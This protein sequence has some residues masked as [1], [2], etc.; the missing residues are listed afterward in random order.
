MIPRA[1]N[2]RGDPSPLPRVLRLAKVL[3]TRFRLP[4]TSL[5][6]GIDP[7]LGLVP[8]LGDAIGL[9]LGSL[10]VFE[11][12]RLGCDRRVLLRMVANLLIDAGIGTI[13]IVGDVLDFF[14]KPNAANAA[15]LSAE[16]AAGR[17]RY[18]RRP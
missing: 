3:D 5:R 15:L 14:I 10:I 12:R 16:H 2:P 8:G 7:L 13:P 11:A 17:L 1:A 9:V 4:G 6:F 18:A